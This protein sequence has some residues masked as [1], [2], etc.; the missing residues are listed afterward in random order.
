[1]FRGI[2]HRRR[3]GIDARKRGI[4]VE[5]TKLIELF[6]MQNVLRDHIGY[7]GE[8]KKDKMLLALLV[9]IGE[10]ANEWRGFKYWSKKNKEPRI[11]KAIICYICDGI[12]E[13]EHDNWKHCERCNGTGVVGY[14][15]PLKEEYVDGLHFVLD[16]GLEIGMEPERLDIRNYGPDGSITK[17]FLVVQE[18]AIGLRTQRNGTFLKMHYEFLLSQYLLLGEMLG[19]SDDDIFNAYVEK[20]KVNHQ[21]QDNGY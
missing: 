19:F 2:R 4:Q 6:K 8:D 15:N 3:E 14:S 18:I 7:E 9:E 20:N 21:R 10:C 1:M 13:L 11:K 17:A 12:G 16:Y 5:K